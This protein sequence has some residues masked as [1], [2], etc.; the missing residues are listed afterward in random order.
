MDALPRML[1]FTTISFGTFATSD[2]NRRSLSHETPD[3]S[4]T[5]LQSPLC[6]C[7]LRARQRHDYNSYHV[8]STVNSML[9]VAAVTRLVGIIVQMGRQTVGPADRRGHASEDISCG[10][11]E[12]S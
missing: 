1:R 9:T 7:P 11:V 5:R 3:T 12:G 2:C 6:A 8:E 4:F 10:Y